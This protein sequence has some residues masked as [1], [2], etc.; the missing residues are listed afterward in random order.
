MF[1]NVL[2]AQVLISVGRRP[3]RP[4]EK[5]QSSA[6]AGIL[7]KTKIVSRG[8]LTLVVRTSGTMSYKQKNI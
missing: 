2:K 1:Y 7:M 4:V 6:I 3:R 8:R 5:M